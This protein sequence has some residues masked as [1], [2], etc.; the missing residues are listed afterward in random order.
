MAVELDIDLV[1]PPHHRDTLSHPPV[2]PLRPVAAAR[3]QVVGV[4]SANWLEPLAQALGRLGCEHAL[5][6]HGDDGL[7]EITLTAAT[8]IA[9]RFHNFRVSA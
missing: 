1:R 3:R 7:D 8:R 2:Q 5:V 6:V 9:E 4:F